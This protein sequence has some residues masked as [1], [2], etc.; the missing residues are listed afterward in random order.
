[1]VKY[2]YPKSNAQGCL[3]QVKEFMYCMKN[4]QNSQRH[5][6]CGNC[7][8]IFKKWDKLSLSQK[9]HMLSLSFSEKHRGF[10]FIEFESAEVSLSYE[11]IMVLVG[12]R[13]ISRITISMI[14]FMDQLRPSG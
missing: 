6:I 2:D 12:L 11:T 14:R 4:E 5:I 9:I 3:W 10:G 1:M 8:C 7:E 13:H